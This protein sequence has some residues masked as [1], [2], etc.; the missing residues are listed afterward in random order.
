MSKEN[1]NLIVGLDIGT[2]YVDLRYPS[3][4]AL[5]VPESLRT[6]HPKPMRRKA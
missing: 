1:K 3:G 6:E 2:D 5:R 4:F